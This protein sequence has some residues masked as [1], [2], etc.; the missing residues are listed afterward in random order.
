MLVFSALQGEAGK[1]GEDSKSVCIMAFE[2][3]AFTNS[4][5]ACVLLGGCA[6]TGLW[7][8][9]TLIWLRGRPGACTW[10]LRWE[11]GLM[12]EAEDTMALASGLRVLPPATADK[13][14]SCGWYELTRLTARVA[15]A[16]SAGGSSLRSSCDMSVRVRLAW[17]R[18]S[19]PLARFEWACTFAEVSATR[20]STLCCCSLPSHSRRYRFCSLRASYSRARF[21]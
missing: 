21:I 6:V 4:F 9:T 17:D 16:A 1:E 11:M 3:M 2:T 5:A 14:W 13:L 20:T 12:A 19:V 15:S 8:I 7:L 10:S 18:T